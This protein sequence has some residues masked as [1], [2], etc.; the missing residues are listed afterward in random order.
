MLPLYPDQV[1]TNG[2][3]IPFKVA[4][5]REMTNK[6]PYVTLEL[7]WPPFLFLQVQ[8]YILKT[9]VCSSVM[10]GLQSATLVSD[11]SDTQS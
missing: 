3:D 2:S 4:S 1:V 5:S 7:L 6:F 9:N 11:T 10:M 8:K